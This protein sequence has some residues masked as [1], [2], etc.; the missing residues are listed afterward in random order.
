M[1][2]GLVND[3]QPQ[4]PDRTALTHTKWQKSFTSF[5]FMNIKQN[6]EKN[7]NAYWISG[8]E[9]SEIMYG[10]FVKGRQTLFPSTNISSEITAWRMPR[11]VR[12]V[13]GSSLAISAEKSIISVKKITIK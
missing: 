7:S 9:S 13:H 8:S 2:E 3:A 11:P 12:K 6:K 10:T 1:A 5:H 4:T